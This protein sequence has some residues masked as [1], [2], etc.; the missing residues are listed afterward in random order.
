MDVYIYTTNPDVQQQLYMDIR[1]ALVLC[2][3]SRKNYAV[4]LPPDCILRPAVGFLHLSL[5]KLL[6]VY[7]ATARCFSS[8]S[9][10]SKQECSFLFCSS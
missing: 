2:L 7:E 1:R 9:Y 10:E 3:H 8:I 6:L 4:S 5:S